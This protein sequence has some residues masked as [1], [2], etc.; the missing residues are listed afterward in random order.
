MDV[1]SQLASLGSVAL[2]ATEGQL[3]TDGSNSLGHNLS[4]S[5]A[6]QLGSIQSIDISRLGS[7]DVLSNLLNQCL[8]VVILSN[9]VS[10]GVDL[11]DTCSVALLA[12]SS[13][14]NTLRSDTASLL[15]SLSDTLLTQPVNSL[16][17]VAFGLNQSLLAVH[18]AS[19]GN[20]AQLFN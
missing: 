19:A 10:L 6:I 13:S 15:S 3:L 17:L 20:L 1:S 4:N 7:N 12:E 14:Y 5:L 8:E 11:N 16:V 18:H 9:E 2:E